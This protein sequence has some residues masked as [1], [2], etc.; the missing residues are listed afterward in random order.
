MVKVIARISS[1]AEATAQ[2]RQVLQELVGPSRKES[3]CVSY[4]LFEEVESPP[5]FITVEQWADERAFDAHMA[6][7]HVA[8]AIAKAGSLLAQPPLIHHFTQ[9]A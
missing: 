3:G 5:D 4:E 8:Q 2:V 9:L 6:T 1:K 7:P